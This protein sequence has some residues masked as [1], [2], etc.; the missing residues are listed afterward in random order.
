MEAI[1]SEIFFDPRL[2]DESPRVEIMVPTTRSSSGKALVD[3]LKRR[4]IPQA[5]LRVGGDART[6]E[7]QVFLFGAKKYSADKV[8]ELLGLPDGRVQQGDATG[9]D[10]DVRVL[11]GTDVKVPGGS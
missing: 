7:T 5:T 10:V 9:V 8:A 4:G 11:L 2:R 1:V 3:Y 6:T